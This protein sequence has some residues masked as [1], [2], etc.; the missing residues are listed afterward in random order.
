[1]ILLELLP[2]DYLVLEYVISLLLAVNWKLGVHTPVSRSPV[3]YP[4]SSLGGC[5]WELVLVSPSFYGTVSTV[6]LNVCGFVGTEE[7]TSGDGTTEVTTGMKSEN[8]VRRIRAVVTKRLV[9]LAGGSK[10]CL[11]VADSSHS[12]SLE[13]SEEAVDEVIL[14]STMFFCSRAHLLHVADSHFPVTD[15]YSGDSS[16][17]SQATRQQLG[18]RVFPRWKRRSV[19][20]SVHS[21]LVRI[22][23]TF[24]YD[25]VVL[26]SIICFVL[27]EIDQVMNKVTQGLSV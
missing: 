3:C 11:L 6:F 26:G 24:P 10:H 8:Q 5:G 15:Q 25:S 16:A 19:N 14:C 2:N 18:L 20:S 9:P 22:L 12:R 27:S 21:W 7:E 23:G 17:V 1:M 13:L 4:E